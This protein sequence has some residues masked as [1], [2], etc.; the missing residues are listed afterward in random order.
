MAWETIHENLKCPKCGALGT[1][2]YKEGDS[3][4]MGGRMS[5]AETTP[6]FT[7]TKDTGYGH[8]TKISC[9]ECKVEVN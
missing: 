1:F 6:G 8:S 4:Y 3:P 7:I 5:D 2:T 9:D